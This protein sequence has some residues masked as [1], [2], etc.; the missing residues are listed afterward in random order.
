MTSVLGDQSP[1][2]VDSLQMPRPFRVAAKTVETHD[3]TTVHVV[4]ADGG[5]LPLFRP[6]QFAMLGA[7]GI[8]EAAISYSST[9]DDVTKHSFTI[10]PAGPITSAL[11]GTAVGGVITVRG[12]FGRPWPIDDLSGG[13]LVVV[14]GGLGIAPLRAVIH[15]ALRRRDDFDEVVLLFGARSPRDLVYRDELATWRAAGADIATIVD[16]GNAG[17]EGPTGLVT[18]LLRE[19][20]VDRIDWPAASAFVCGPEEMMRHVAVSLTELGMAPSTIWLTL[21]R[22][23]QC[24]TGLCGH[25]QLGPLIVCRDGPVVP[26][27]RLGRTLEVSEL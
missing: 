7:F 14:G 20:I 24:G 19:A 22:N 15:E 18:D 26:L 23:M 6:A 5:R 11:T 9:T 17:W 2:V 13:T 21:E 10:R 25:C 8:G 4:P 12:P 27:E 16:T 1:P 3:V